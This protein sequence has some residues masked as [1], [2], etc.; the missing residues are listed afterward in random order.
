[1]SDETF[2]NFSHHPNMNDTVKVLNVRLSVDNPLMVRHDGALGRA[3]RL[4]LRFSF[5][6]HTRTSGAPA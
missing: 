5:Y 2:G 1:M 4:L 3:I 6:S